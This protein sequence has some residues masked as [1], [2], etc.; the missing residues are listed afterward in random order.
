[1]KNSEINTD[2]NSLPISERMRLASSLGE[3]VGKTLNKALE[4]CNKKLK[5][6]GYSV[7]IVL[8]F[9]EL[10]EENKTK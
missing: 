7:S 1:M 5:K 6:Y 3:E 8:N 2:M 10:E 9:H 4:K